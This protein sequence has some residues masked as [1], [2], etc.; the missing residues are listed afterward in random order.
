MGVVK[1][2]ADGTDG[3][4]VT[5]LGGHLEVLDVGDLALGVEDGDAGVRHAR[6]AVQGRLAGVSGGGGDDHH[7]PAVARACHTHELR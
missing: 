2:A 4:V 7:V 6:K 5:G 3:H 1:V